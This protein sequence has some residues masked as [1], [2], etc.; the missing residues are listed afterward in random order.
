MK[1][2]LAIG[3]LL[4]GVF[5]LGYGQKEYQSQKFLRETS[6]AEC[7]KTWESKGGAFIIKTG[8][9]NSE[10]EPRTQKT[11]TSK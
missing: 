8:P 1:K 7:E 9:I 6:M 2:L 4:V 3:T 5:M 10:L 11:E